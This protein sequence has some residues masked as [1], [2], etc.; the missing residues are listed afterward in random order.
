MLCVCCV[1]HRFVLCVVYVGQLSVLGRDGEGREERRGN[2][3]EFFVVF[4]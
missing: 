4:N 3:V 1:W 2:L